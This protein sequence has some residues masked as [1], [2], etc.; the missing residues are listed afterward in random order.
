MQ[1]L[2][3]G[4]ADID[5]VFVDAFKIGNRRHGD[6]NRSKV[7][8]LVK[9]VF[10]GQGIEEIVLCLFDDVGGVDEEE[11]VSIAFFVEVEN[12]AR[13]DEGFAASGCHIEQEMEG[14]LFAFG[15]FVVE[16]QEEP[17]EGFVLIGAEFK[18]G[19]Q[20]VTER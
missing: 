7:D 14:R 5:V 16:T 11:E 18:F 15:K 6:A 12:Q 8:G 9:Q 17:R 2:D 19:V 4:E 1:L 10:G 13:H 3:G 20:V